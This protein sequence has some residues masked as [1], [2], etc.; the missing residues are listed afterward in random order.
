MDRDGNLFSQLDDASKAFMHSHCEC[1]VQE[2]QE[3]FRSGGAVVG[4]FQSATLTT[5][6]SKGIMGS[7]LRPHLATMVHLP[8]KL[9]T[10]AGAHAREGV[11]HLRRPRNIIPRNIMLYASNPPIDVIVTARSISVVEHTFIQNLFIQKHIHSHPMTLSSHHT[12]V[13]NV[14]VGWS[15]PRH[16]TSGRAEGWGPKGVGAQKGGGPNPRPRPWTTQIVRLAPLVILCEPRTRALIHPAS[17][18][19]GHVLARPPPGLK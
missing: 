3:S 15:W 9:G 5:E 6:C 12:F 17:S 19:C 11:L 4:G 10:S 13:Q 1:V 14:V 18:E 2:R 7:F 8:Q 16:R